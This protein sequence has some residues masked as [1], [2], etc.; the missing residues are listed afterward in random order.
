LKGIDTYGDLL[1]CSG[2]INRSH[3]IIKY[4]DVLLSTG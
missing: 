2:C 3:W 4:S 1:V